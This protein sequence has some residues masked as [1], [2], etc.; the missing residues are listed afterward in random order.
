M[1]REAS[2]IIT[3]SVGFFLLAKFFLAVP[4]VTNVANEIE[5][6]CIVVFAFAIVLGV[7]NIVRF[8]LLGIIR[9]RP[10]WEYKVVLLVTMLIT[11]VAGLVVFFQGGD[12]TSDNFFNWI[13]VHVLT[14]LGASMYAL[15]AFFIASA[16]FRA[17][18]AKNAAASFMLGAALLVMIGRVPLGAAIS[19][20]FP[21]IANWIM[22]YPNAA[23]QRGIIIGAAIGVIAVGLKIITGIERPYLRGE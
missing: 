12:I 7:A 13:Y 11:A 9:R 1:R 16:A 8:N 5:Q 15:L 14:P 20:L 19:A 21:K 23:G 18:R 2:L 3:I 17:F 4:F 6:W 22:A 10:D